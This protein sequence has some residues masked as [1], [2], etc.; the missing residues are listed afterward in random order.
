[1]LE[2][3][4]D[5]VD[6]LAAENWHGAYYELALRLGP[7]AEA[8]ADDR[9]LAA[10]EAVWAHPTLFGPVRDRTKRRVDQ[11]QVLPR[12]SELEHPENFYGVASLPDGRQSVCLTCVVREI[13]QHGSDWLDLCLPTGALVRVDPR[14]GGYPFGDIHQARS[15]REPLDGWFMSVARAVAAATTFELGLIGFEVSGEDGQFDG[16]PPAERSVGYVLQRGDGI[17]EFPPTRWDS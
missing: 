16:G 4:T 7:R 8:N 12:P 9:L 11:P 2:Q 13:D 10:L 17:E 3:V 1:M 6:F 14:I 5:P 15:W